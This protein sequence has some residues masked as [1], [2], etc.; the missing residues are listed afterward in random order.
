MGELYF[1]Q[2]IN[3]YI[4]INKE[5]ANVKIESQMLKKSVNAKE[6]YY[7]PL[8]CIDMDYKLEFTISN[9]NKKRVM[10]P[11]IL[12]IFRM[13]DSSEIKLYY[14]LEEFNELRYEV[15]ENIKKVY[16]I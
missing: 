9:I 2:K 10:K 13:E 4:L 8:K 6:N 15:A 5:E 3:N 16:G 7:Q 1:D 14:S 12:L 11:I